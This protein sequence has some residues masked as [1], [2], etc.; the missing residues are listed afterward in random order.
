MKKKFTVEKAIKYCEEIGVNMIMSD[1]NWLEE[2]AVFKLFKVAKKHLSYYV[3]DSFEY[4]DHN[5]LVPGDLQ[6]R[7]SDTVWLDISEVKRVNDQNVN[8]LIK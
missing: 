6:L 7:D 8:D 4:E 2:E 1:T 5:C 3:E